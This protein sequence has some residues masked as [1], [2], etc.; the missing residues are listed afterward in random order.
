MGQSER[1]I[2]RIS[3]ISS[4][5]RR[6]TSISQAHKLAKQSFDKNCPEIQEVWKGIKNKLGPA[7]I[8]KDPILLT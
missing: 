4:L 3:Q 1:E 6:L 7:Q 2:T 8:R 5:S